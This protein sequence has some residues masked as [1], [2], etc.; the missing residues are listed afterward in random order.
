MQR[1]GASLTGYVCGTPDGGRRASQWLG[2]PPVDDLDRLVATDPSTIAIC[3]P[4]GALPRVASDLASAL[5]NNTH[6]KGGTSAGAGV[7]VLHT[8]GA[9]SVHTLDPCA[10]QGAVILAFH[11]LQTFSEPVS[12]SDHFAGCAIAV[13]AAKPDPSSP[14]LQEG[15]SLALGLSARPFM[16]ADDKR[17]VYHAAACMASNYLVTLESCAERLF[18]ESGMPREDA[19]SLFL[20]LVRAAVDNLAAQGAVSALT[21]PLSR[22]DVG[23]IERHLDALDAGHPDMAAVY[24]RLG[25][26]T[27]DLVRTAAQVDEATV[28]HLAGLLASPTSPRP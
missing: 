27:L 14:G 21:G 15:F 16:L 20:P 7:L 12:G 8:S 28:S 22:G 6:L 23:T 24:R 2:R 11:P 5:G 9:G 13:T 10:A 18:V 3:V 17:T 4:D 25:L 1:A 26:A 19:M